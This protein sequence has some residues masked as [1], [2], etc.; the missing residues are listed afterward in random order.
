MSYIR[1]FNGRTEEPNNTP[2]IGTYTCPEHG[3]FDC[4]VRRDARG[5]AP[6]VIECPVVYQLF[7]GS[8]EFG[9]VHCRLESRWTPSPSIAC[10]V[11]RVEVVR[12]KWEKPERKTFLDTRELGEGQSM[13]EFRAKREKVWEERRREDIKEMLR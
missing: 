13:E 12:G 8:P 5:E 6:D 10:R 3:E 2:I 4:E 11:R 9:M 1:K 7:E